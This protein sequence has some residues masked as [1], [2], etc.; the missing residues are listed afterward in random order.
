MINRSYYNEKRFLE[1]TFHPVE[2]AEFYSKDEDRV[3]YEYLASRW[4]LK[5][6]MVKATGRTDLEYKGIYLKK[7]KYELEQEGQTVLRKLRP[8]VDVSGERNLMIFK[9]LNVVAIH[10]SISHEQDYAVAFVTLET[11]VL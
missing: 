11:E 6:A 10:S 1:G 7:P 5:E 9:E 3:R 2:Q 8:V 4:A